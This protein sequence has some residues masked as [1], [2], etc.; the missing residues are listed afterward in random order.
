MP[1]GIERLYR[2]VAPAGFAAAW[3]GQRIAGSTKADLRSRR[4]H[5]PPGKPPLLW[6]HGASAGETAG[7]LRLA[8][9]LRSEGFTFTA[10][11]TAANSAGVQ[12]ADAQREEGDIATLAPWDVARWIRRSFDIWQPKALFLVEGELWPSLTMEAARR[13]VPIFCVSARIYQRDVR[14]Y[15]LIRSLVRPMLQRMTA[16]LTADDAER[17]RFLDLGAPADRCT[18]AGNLKYLPWARR[19]RPTPFDRITDRVPRDRLVVCGSIH[20]DE[21]RGLFSAL[22]ALPQDVRVVIAPR[23]REATPVIRHEAGRRDWSTW[24]RSDTRS[25]DAWRILLLDTV[26]ELARAYG[27]GCV[28]VVGG[29]FERHGGHNP[30]EPVAEETPVLLGSHFH[31]FAEEA[32]ALT[33]AC[34]E[35]TVVDFN[36]LGGRLRQW[37]EDPAQSLDA[38]SRQK[39]ALPNARR[40]ADQYRA[41]LVPW[42]DR[43]GLRREET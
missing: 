21:V 15:T 14:G 10:A 13:R 36:E 11:F 20:A 8:D 31:H 2:I 32:A 40:I 28:A 7:A 30:F 27:S 39:S 1:S 17:Q 25:D 6:F 23:H 34:P 43:Q 16:I 12:L 9:L 35:T 29:G 41:I 18:G 33:S 4:G 24:V 38:L 3:M 26:G 19:S 42:M 5:L 22:D 37:L